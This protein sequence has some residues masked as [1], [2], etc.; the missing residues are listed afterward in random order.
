MYTSYDV[1]LS[2]HRSGF[3][4]SETLFAAKSHLHLSRFNGR[5][6][7]WMAEL[8]AGQNLTLPELAATLEEIAVKG[9]DGQ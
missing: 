8:E 2:V 1:K 5:L 6:V 4:V 9:P 3:H 7:E